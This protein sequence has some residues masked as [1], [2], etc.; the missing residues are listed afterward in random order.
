MRVRYRGR[1]LPGRVR[2]GA[3]GLRV[4]LD[5][6]ADGV[7]AGQTAAL[8]RDHRL[9]AAGTIAPNWSPHS[10]LSEGKH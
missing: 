2:A 8:Y 4:S 7:A 9:V 3:S 5:E 6:A 1:A 10:R